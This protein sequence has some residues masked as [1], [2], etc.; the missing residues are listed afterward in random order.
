MIL[1]IG[2]VLTYTDTDFI[3]T[4]YQL[5]WYRY[6]EYLNRYIGIGIIDYTDNTDYRTGPTWHT[7]ILFTLWQD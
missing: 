3:I 1:F 7:F 5:Y 2:Q 4:G 6:Q